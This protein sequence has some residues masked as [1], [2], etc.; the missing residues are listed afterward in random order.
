MTRTLNL[1]ALVVFA[2]SLF[3]RS[4]DPVVPQIAFG[5]NVEPATASLLTSAFSLPYALVQPFLG[6]LGDMMSKARLMLLCVFV[7]VGATIVCGAAQ[8]FEVLIAARM[9]AGMAAGGVVP[10]AFALVGDMVPVAERQVALGRVLFAIMT[11]NLFG[12][13]FAGVV[14]D[15]VGWRGVFFSLG[16]FGML[17]LASAAPGFRGIK[18][19]P[20]QVD[21][22][23]AV[24]NYRTIFRNPLAKI[25]FGAVFLEDV[26]EELVGEVRDE[27]QRRAG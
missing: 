22:R 19:K 21:L 20:G 6:A 8:S 27:S 24:S 5:L 2:C 16:I 18:E 11:G 10:I 3:L 14:N 17:V 23:A 26:L 13:T 25:C 1:I 7:V 15:L 4:T 9:V 12:A